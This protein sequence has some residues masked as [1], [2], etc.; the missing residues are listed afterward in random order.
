MWPSGT[1]I[2]REPRSVHASTK[3]HPAGD[4]GYALSGPLTARILYH[5]LPQRKG[6]RRAIFQKNPCA[7][8]NKIGISPPPPQNPKYPPPKTRNFMD[9]GFFRQ[10]ERIF[11]GVHKIGAAISGPRI[12]DR[13]C[14]GCEDFFNFCHREREFE[15]QYWAPWTLRIF[16]RYFLPPKLFLFSVVIWKGPPII[17][18]KTSARVTSRGYF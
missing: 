10:K 15:G 18:F 8:K 3:Q 14:Y 13:K 5:F 1:F 6:V 16:W 12:T 2:K 11:P 7:Q 4:I 17:S 9:M